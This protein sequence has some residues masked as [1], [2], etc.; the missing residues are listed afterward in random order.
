MTVMDF[1]FNPKTFRDLVHNA[2]EPYLDD[3]PGEGD[4]NSLS[5]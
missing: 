5:N 3:E 2:V 4:M 1:S